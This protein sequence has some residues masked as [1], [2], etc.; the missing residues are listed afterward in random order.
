ML[1]PLLLLA[2]AAALAASTLVPAPTASAQPAAATQHASAT[3]PITDKAGNTWLA[4]TGFEGGDIV[5]RGAEMKVEPP[6]D[7]ATAAAFKTGQYPPELYRTERYDVT[8]FT[9]SLPNGKYLVHLHFAETYE[10]ITAAG[11]RIFSL[12][13]EGQDVKDLDVCKEAGGARKPLIKTFTVDLKDG[14]LTITFTPKEQSP[15]INA[16]EILPQP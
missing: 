13:V 4:E 3:T 11:Q 12:N 7:P 8:K 2:V 9:R 14:Q 10:E 1:R 15:M 5:D 16:I 6:T